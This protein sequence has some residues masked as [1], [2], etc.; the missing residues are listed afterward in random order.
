VKVCVTGAS[1]KAGRAV[2]ADLLAHGYELVAADLVAPSE[3]LGVDVRLGDLTDYDVAPDVLEGTEA[4]VHLANIPAPDIRPPVETF[5]SNVTMNFNVFYA[6]TEAGLRRV[7]WASSETTL[8]VPFDRPRY[9]P[10]DED[11][12]PF[13]PSTY[14][15]SK[16]AGETIAAQIAA[17]SGIP[18]VALRFSN[19]LGLEDYRKFP[20]CRG[21]VAGGVPG[22]AGATRGRDVREPA[23]RRARPRGDRLRARALLARRPM[24]FARPPSLIRT[25]EISTRR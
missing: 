18:F 1:G 4:V 3:G 15:L 2:V 19:I 14:A 25:E 10:V 5:N 16:V 23:L 9:V 8:G 6:T 20:S 22:R 13:S 11:H 17:W 24:I 7:V 21:A 12:Y